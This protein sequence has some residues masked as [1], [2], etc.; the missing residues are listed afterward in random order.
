MD[1]YDGPCPRSL[2]LCEGF[3]PVAG[4]G[5]SSGPRSRP[6]SK[7]GPR[8]RSGPGPKR[9]CGS[10]DPA[11]GPAPG[12][13]SGVKAAQGAP[14]AS[15]VR[16]PRSK[17]REPLH[18]PPKAPKHG[19]AASETMRQGRAS[20]TKEGG[21]ALGF[22]Q[23]ILP[24][25]AEGA[26][27]RPN[28]SEIIR[29]RPPRSP[30]VA[31]SRPAA[32]APLPRPF[33]RRG[34]PAVD[35]ARDL[36]RRRASRDPRVGACPGPRAWGATGAVGESAWPNPRVWPPFSDRPHVFAGHFGAGDDFKKSALCAACL[37]C[38][39]LSNAVVN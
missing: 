14:R 28:A 11:A 32:R 31:R 17:L 5:P 30:G 24:T 35:S 10:A 8:P 15:F 16:R 9:S 22:G 21:Q 29:G 33:Q 18:D 6:R 2:C 25:P 23:Q 36:L 1:N 37:R 26:Q 19:S 34:T 7:S 39:E 12:P 20:S 4:H 3:R 27:W 13:I 38:G